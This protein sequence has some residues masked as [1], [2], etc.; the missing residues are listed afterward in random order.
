M[1]SVLLKRI[2]IL[3]IILIT[4]TSAAFLTWKIR[5]HDKDQLAGLLKIYTAYDKDGNAIHLSRHGKAYDGGYVVPERAFMMSDVLLGY[6]IA[7][8]ISFEEQFSDIYK[9]PSYGFDCDIETIQSKNKLFAFYSECIGSDK[10]LNGT[11][12]SSGKISTFDQQL[13]RLHLEDKKIFIKMDIEGAE[14]DVFQDIL[15]H[16]SNITGIVIEIHFQNKSSIKK[17]I[18]FL[19]ELQKDFI[20]LHV[21]GNNNASKRFTSKYAVGEIPQVLELTYINKN[22]VDHYDVSSNQKHPVDMDMPNVPEKKDDSFEI[23]LK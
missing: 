4:V 16:Q 18:N 9:K 11:Q 14:Y 17:A 12:E 6:G 15:K 19:Q 22:L 20:L 23:I 5:H 2:V 13:T 1:K 7:D 8:D 10:F 21:H 3:S